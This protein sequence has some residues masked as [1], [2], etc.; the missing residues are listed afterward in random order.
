MK[1]LGAC[2]I[3]AAA[4]SAGVAAFAGAAVKKVAV[5]S[6]VLAGKLY[7]GPRKKLDMED[8]RKTG[9]WLG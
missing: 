7:P 5:V 9:R 3:S 4:F 8:V 2:A 1:A 6:A